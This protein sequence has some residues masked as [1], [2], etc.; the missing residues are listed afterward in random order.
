[1]KKVSIGEI[2]VVD[3]IHLSYSHTAGEEE[4]A[5]AIEPSESLKRTERKTVLGILMGKRKEIAAG[6][7]NDTI[8]EKERVDS[9]G[10]VYR[11]ISTPIDNLHYKIWDE[12]VCKRDVHGFMKAKINEELD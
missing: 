4:Y 1:M 8:M 6:S 2:I 11:A 9:F 3:I 12:M 7:A 5:E 10:S